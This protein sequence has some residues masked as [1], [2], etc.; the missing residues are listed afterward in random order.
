MS[1]IFTSILRNTSKNSKNLNKMIIALLSQTVTLLTRKIKK[2]TLRNKIFILKLNLT[3]HRQK[4]TIP[5]FLRPAI[6][7]EISSV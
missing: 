5:L 2:Y 7:S 6:I 1:S 3:Y 4:M